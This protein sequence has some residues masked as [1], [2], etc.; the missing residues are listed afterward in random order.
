MAVASAVL[1]TCWEQNIYKMKSNHMNK[2]LIVCHCHSTCQENENLHYVQLCGIASEI[3]HEMVWMCWQGL[4]L[5]NVC[6]VFCVCLWFGKKAFV[7]FVLYLDFLYIRL[8]CCQNSH[9]ESAYNR[10]SCLE[11]HFLILATKMGRQICFMVI[12]MTRWKEVQHIK[13]YWVPAF[14]MARLWRVIEG[15][16]KLLQRKLSWG[17]MCPL[18][19][20]PSWLKLRRPWLVIITQ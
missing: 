5:P 2:V 19:Y 4:Q 7:Y 16:K 8:F 17:G 18:F 3:T 14:H 1:C 13:D 11:F 15:K 9:R 6:F 20:S 10:L 12:D